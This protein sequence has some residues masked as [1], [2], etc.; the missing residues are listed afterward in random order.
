MGWGYGWRPYVPVWKRQAQ[1]EREMAKLRKEGVDVQPVEIEGREIA[2]TFWGK[3]WCEHIEQFSDFEN[4]LPRGRTYVRNGSVCHLEIRKGRIVAKVSGSSVYDVK[5]S[6]RTLPE[7][8]WRCLRN[9][10]AGH[11]GS[12]LELLQGRLSDY[13]M[14]IVTD[15]ERGLFPKP[16]EMSFDCSCPDW[17]NMCKHVAAVLYG[18][19]ARL[20]K[21]PELLF[22]LRGVDHRELV[23]E[24]AAGAVVA[25]GKSKKDRLLDEKRLG[26]VFGI[27]L[28]TDAGKSGDRASKASAGKARHPVGGTKPRAGKPKS[29]IAGKRM[30]QG[31]T[32][33]GS[34]VGTAAET[35]PASDPEEAES[36]AS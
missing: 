16:A 4:R 5:I 21:S 2:E 15:P 6:I 23:S 8:K 34:G 30:R 32:G 25:R 26:D 1:A 20:D 22:R 9:E 13:V 29:P 7:A 11:V 28:E 24:K 18:V 12:M 3:A 35:C 10:C 31:G 27:E 36:V 19:G 17:A 14:G 33:A